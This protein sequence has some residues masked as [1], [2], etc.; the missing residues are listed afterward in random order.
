M[1]E[2]PAKAIARATLALLALVAMLGA[3]TGIGL[4]AAIGGGIAVAVIAIAAGLGLVAAGLLGGPRWLILPVI[5]LIM[6]LA[7]VSAADIDLRGGVGERQF[8]PQTRRRPAARS[9]GS[10]SGRWTS[11]CAAWTLTAST[12][13]ST[14]SWAWAR[15]ACG[16]P[17]GPAWSRTRRSASARPT[18]P[19]PRARASTS[20]STTARPGA[21]TLRVN[22]KIGVGHLQIDDAGRL[23]MKRGRADRTLIV[24]GLATIVLGALL[25]LDRT[26]AIDVRFDYML[27]AVLAAV[28]AVL[29]AAGLFE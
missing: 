2:D 4:I 25:L 28:G 10:A 3:A 29:L 16:C 14:C 5:V 12:R 9:T 19:S 23:R 7:V 21:R 1:R 6:P 15:R 24:A 22:A 27:P 13:R 26:G 11:T 17:P 18:C 8:R 20:R